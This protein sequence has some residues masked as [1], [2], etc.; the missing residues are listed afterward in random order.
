V[1]VLHFDRHAVIGH[2]S[3]TLAV[4]LQAE[5]GANEAGLRWTFTWGERSSLGT[6]HGPHAYFWFTAREQSVQVEVTTPGYG[7]VGC[8]FA[9][10]HSPIADIADP[11]ALEARD[12]RGLWLQVSRPW[13]G[14][15][16]AAFPEG[17]E[18]DD[19]RTV[20][21][22]VATIAQRAAPMW[23]DVAS[24]V[25]RV[26][27]RIEEN[28]VLAALVET[29][30]VWLEGF[31][32]KLRD[33]DLFRVR[34]NLD[35]DALI[36]LVAGDDTSSAHADE[37]EEVELTEELG[38]AP[39]PLAPWDLGEPVA[40]VTHVRIGGSALDRHARHAGEHELVPA[41]GDEVVRAGHVIARN[42]PGSAGYT[43]WIGLTDFTDTPPAA[44]DVLTR[45][46][47]IVARAVEDPVRGR[48][49]Y[50]W[51]PWSGAS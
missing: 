28:D 38:G 34:S 35:D 25:D 41:A 47:A 23:E 27:A 4:E 16:T 32:L 42:V 48:R 36:A 15:Y 33:T 13:K 11:K 22:T 18:A 46:G 3:A 9:R 21:S 2:E 12:E 39:V 49:G 50:S 26:R 1:Q 6:G 14:E 43:K 17:Q 20:L 51:E 44:G 5:R 45:S 8:F 31:L 19:W 29:V 37:P 24:S 10:L 30:S 40:V 7:L